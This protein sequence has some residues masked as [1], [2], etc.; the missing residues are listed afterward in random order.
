MHNIVVDRLLPR[1]IEASVS[2]PGRSQ[3]AGLGEFAIVD[4]TYIYTFS[5]GLPGG[6]LRSQGTVTFVSGRSR[7]SPSNYPGCLI[8]VIG[9]A[10]RRDWFMVVLTIAIVVTFIVGILIEQ[11]RHVPD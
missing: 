9:A 6:V 11:R 8:S 2:D 1:P 4:R 3:A 10:I 5:V 7:Q